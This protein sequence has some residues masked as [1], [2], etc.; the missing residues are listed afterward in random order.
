MF[1]GK[2]AAKPFRRMKPA[3]IQREELPALV[4]KS[5][6]LISKTWKRKFRG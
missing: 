5:P 4:A 3:A 1:A 2:K 6:A